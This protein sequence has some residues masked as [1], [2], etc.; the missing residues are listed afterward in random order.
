MRGGDWEL[1]GRL[2]VRAAPVQYDRRG[3]NPWWEALPY[4]QLKELCKA[5]KDFG[6]NSP[7]FKNLIQATFAAN[8]LVPHDINIMSCLLSP[9]KY[10]L[11]ERTWKR[12]LQNLLQS[13]RRDPN[14]PNLALD[15]LG[16]EGDLEKPQYQAKLL[17][18][19]VLGD[20]K[21]LTE[22]AF[23]LTPSNSIPSHNFST[24]KQA[25]DESFIKF[26]DRLKES[27]EKQGE[28]LEAQK[29][30]LCVLAMAN[31]NENCKKILQALPLDPAPTIDKMIEA[32]TKLTSPEVT[33]AQAV[34]QGVVEALAVSNKIQRE[35][36]RCFKHLVKNCPEP[37]DSN[38]HS[39]SVPPDC[40]TCKHHHQKHLGNG[41]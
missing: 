23:F 27:V 37:K 4:E 14:R 15:Q 29:E 32:C 9:A 28:N 25:V 13:Y 11:W 34:S 22:R 21:R 41:H 16:G 31:A 17:S 24:I 18:E 40:P 3:G 8:T 26:I 19:L 39:K 7:Y 30:L 38:K 33:I 12:L 36:L 1:A 2:D 10:M 20:T 35:K 5:G 6:W